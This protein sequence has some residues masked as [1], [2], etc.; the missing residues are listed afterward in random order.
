MAPSVLFN[1]EIFA[2]S[3]AELCGTKSKPV[4]N[5]IHNI[6]VRLLTSLAILVAMLVGAVDLLLLMIYQINPC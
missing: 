2:D 3:A 5:H 1:A 6:H 4:P